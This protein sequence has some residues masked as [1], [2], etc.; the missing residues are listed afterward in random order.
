MKKRRIKSNNKRT[1]SP[2]QLYDVSHSNNN[3]LSSLF[4]SHR[5]LEDNTDGEVVD[6]P[7]PSTN[8]DDSQLIYIA[9]EGLL[10]NFTNGASDE[11]DLCTGISNFYNDLCLTNQFV[12]PK[13][14]DIDQPRN[15]RPRCCSS[16]SLKYENECDEDETV[17]DSGLA[18]AATFFLICIIV[19]SMIR[20]YNVKWLPE[21]GGVTLVGAVIGLVADRCYDYKFESFDDAIFMRILLPPIIFDA[22][23][24]VDKRRFRQ[25]LGPILMLAFPGTL[26][27]SFVTGGIVY[28]LIY[29]FSKYCEEIPFLE[30]LIWGSL[31]SSIDPVAT[32]GALTDNGLTHDGKFFSSYS[33]RIQGETYHS[34]PSRFD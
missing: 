33:K 26:V 19:R 2:R 30:C 6:T 14:L 1:S 8:S 25:H 4:V 3:Q 16:L 24:S 11:S 18:G 22:A 5:I 12:W 31:I 29:G 15:F 9:C 34:L 28:G 21:V 10:K 7:S 17:S 27:C 23:L 13:D 32:I 20:K